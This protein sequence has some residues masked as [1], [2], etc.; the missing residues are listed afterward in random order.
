MIFVLCN[1]FVFV[2]LRM[3]KCCEWVY[4]R[5]IGVYVVCCIVMVRVKC[6]VWGCGDVCVDGVRGGWVICYSWRVL[7]KI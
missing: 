3:W 1:V 7:R 4:G 2:V 5:N 6:I